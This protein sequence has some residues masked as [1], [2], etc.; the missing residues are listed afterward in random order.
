MT[1]NSK[2]HILIIELKGIGNTACIIPLLKYIDN[3]NNYIFDLIVSNNGSDELIDVFKYSNLKNIIIWDIHKSYINNLFSISKIIRE[4]HYDIAIATYPSGAKEVILLYVAKSKVKK[5]LRNK[6]GYIRFLQ[7]LFSN[8][9]MANQDI[10]EVENNAILFGVPVEH[11]RNKKIIYNIDKIKIGIHIGSKGINRRWDISNWVELIRI[12]KSKYNAIIYLIAGN[13]EKQLINEIISS[14][15]VDDLLIGMKFE[16]LLRNIEKLTLLI[17]NDS[18]IAHIS[19]LLN[20]PTVVIWSYSQ[21]RRIS[22][23]GKGTVII[24]H[25][26]DCIPCYNVT[27]KYIDKCKYN[28]RCIKNTKVNDVSQILNI[29][30]ESLKSK[31]L[32]DES[33]YKEMESLSKIETLAWGT[34]I[35][36]LK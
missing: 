21:Y 22:P 24:T 19:A 33:K 9:P 8:A 16:E 34:K 11:L 26:Y 17:G 3:N 4:Y 29:Y 2:T 1:D 27:N 35:L 6:G 7:F 13:N 32:P 12:L 30:I 28:F 10:H 5:I 15:E 14:V 23:Y 31:K 20:I 18:S 25:D 36:Y